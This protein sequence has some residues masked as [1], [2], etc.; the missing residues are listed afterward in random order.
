MTG[1][2]D[3]KDIELSTDT[4]LYRSIFRMLQLRISFEWKND[5]LSKRLKSQASQPCSR[6]RYGWD[7]KFCV[8]EPGGNDDGS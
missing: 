6:P 5:I 3:L 2:S 1:R 8:S 4:K 7:K